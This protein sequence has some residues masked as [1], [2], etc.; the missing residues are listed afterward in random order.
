M[1]LGLGLGLI[2]WFLKSRPVDVLY[3]AVFGTFPGLSLLEHLH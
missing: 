3:Q 1:D 2:V